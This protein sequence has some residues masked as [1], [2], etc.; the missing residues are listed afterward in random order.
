[1]D[2]PGGTVLEVWKHGRCRAGH[3]TLIRYPARGD[4]MKHFVRR[5]IEQF[6]RW[7]A[8]LLFLGL[9]HWILLQF[10]D[11]GIVI[12]FALIFVAACF[13]AWMFDLGRRTAG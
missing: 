1:M 3:S 9:G 11:T 10:K 12:A 2:R 6:D 7:S 13:R 4:I 8:A 5:H